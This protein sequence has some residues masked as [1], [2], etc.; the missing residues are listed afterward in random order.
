[1]ITFDVIL[2]LVYMSVDYPLF[3]TIFLVIHA[4]LP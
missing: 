2:R 1:M 3:I 4:F